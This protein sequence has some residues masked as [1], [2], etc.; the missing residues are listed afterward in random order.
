MNVLPYVRTDGIPSMRNSFIESLWEKMVADGVVNSVFRD[1]SIVCRDDFVNYV[2]SEAVIFCVAIENDKPAGM[3]WLNRIEKRK[4]WVH[5][6]VFS[7]HW[8][9]PAVDVGKSLVS[10]LINL[11]SNG[12]FVFDVFLGLTPKD[13]RLA[14]RFIRKVGA[15]SLGEVKS[16]IWNAADGASQPAIFSCYEREP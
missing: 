2:T 14:V 12:E 9:A 13:N 15:K 11:K 8:G 10:F 4:A 7:S 1:G 5:F 16:G 6:C 3:A